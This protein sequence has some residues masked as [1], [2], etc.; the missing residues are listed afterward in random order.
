MY[1]TVLLILYACHYRILGYFE[2]YLCENNN[3]AVD[4]NIDCFDNGHLLT[5]AGTDGSTR[6]SIHDVIELTYS[7]QLDMPKGV[8]CSQ[9]ILRWKYNAGNM[10]IIFPVQIREV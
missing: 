3:M 8:T 10:L 2:F 9:C 5:I 6:Y 7:F 1:A 4:P